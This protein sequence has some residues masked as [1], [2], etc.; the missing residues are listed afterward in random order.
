MKT[1]SS[2]GSRFLRA[3]SV[4]GVG[5]VCLG[6]MVLAQKN[7]IQPQPQAD[8]LSP[9]TVPTRGAGGRGVRARPERVMP[10]APAGFTVSVYAETPAPRMMV[11]APN[12][13]LFVSPPQCN[14]ITVLRDAN[15]DGVF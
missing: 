6:A 4:T 5:V 15:N 3:I 13:D 11:Y 7:S 9:I 8:K 1:T 10:T 2:I 14:D 12:G